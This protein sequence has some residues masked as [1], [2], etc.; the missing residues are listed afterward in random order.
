MP[1]VMTPNQASS[2]PVSTTQSPTTAM[3]NEYKSQSDNCDARFVCRD[4]EILC[5]KGFVA[6]KSR[7]MK[8]YLDNYHVV[9]MPR[10]YTDTIQICLDI[11]YFGYSNRTPAFEGQ[12]RAY[13]KAFCIQD[14][15]DLV[16]IAL[17]NGHGD[18]HASVKTGP[19][20]NGNSVVEEPTLEEELNGQDARSDSGDELETFQDSDAEN[21]APSTETPNP[22]SAAQLSSGGKAN[23][24]LPPI[25]EEDVAAPV[26]EEPPP[27]ADDIQPEPGGSGMQAPLTQDEVEVV[28]VVPAKPKRVDIVDLASSEDEEL[29]LA[30][31]V[32]LQETLRSAAAVE[33][34]F[35]RK[36][37][38][39]PV[40]ST[41]I[42]I[43]VKREH[44][45]DVRCRYCKRPFSS[46]Q[47]P[48]HMKRA[49]RRHPQPLSSKFLNAMER[50]V[51]IVNFCKRKRGNAKNRTL[52]AKE[53]KS[54]S[55]TMELL[56][57]RSNSRHH[58][59]P[60]SGRTRLLLTS[61]F[62]KTL[63]RQPTARIKIEEED[64][65]WGDND[66]DWGDE[67]V[68]ASTITPSSSNSTTSTTVKAQPVPTTTTSSAPVQ[69]PTIRPLASIN[70]VQT[71]NTLNLISN[72]RPVQTIS[73]SM[74]L[75][76]VPTIRYV[77]PVQTFRQ[78]SHHSMPVINTINPR[79]GTSLLL[80]NQQQMPPMIPI[81]PAPQPIQ[82]IT[83]AQPQLRYQQFPNINQVQTSVPQLVRLTPAPVSVNPL[84]HLI[85]QRRPGQPLA[86]AP[87]PVVVSA[88]YQPAMSNAVHTFRQNVA[89]RQI[90]P[91]Q[92][93]F[94][95]GQQLALAPQMNINRSAP[96]ADH[97][98]GQPTASNV[99]LPIQEID[100]SVSIPL[101]PLVKINCQ[102]CL[103]PQV[104][105]RHKTHE[106]GCTKKTEPQHC[107]RCDAVFFSSQSLTRHYDEAHGLHIVL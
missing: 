65:V 6:S 5:H 7:E 18:D 64:L 104:P 100:L 12:T 93:T 26:A 67:T 52:K 32:S 70:P 74:P 28:P 1:G 11:L 81:V 77:N 75:Q 47:L 79:A 51:D 25:Q 44:I 16:G 101:P 45:T 43:E 61:I 53:A 89:P 34:I 29:E 37:P 57:R 62:R 14:V 99:S 82:I 13:A 33:E 97:S 49:H 20:T 86:A 9:H 27:L 4:G 15:D 72:V 73:Q 83:N 94:N 36:S 31:A 76:Q 30:K 66:M 95:T 35:K 54:L 10:A 107:R 24:A 85:Q 41:F 78:A 38:S 40:A 19:V 22:V 105:N 3:K 46:Y 60:S 17:T 21:D 98:Y 68:P 96:R 88:A 103:K 59:K 91:A 92:Q 106:K 84:G 23:E 42:P 56:S 50:P 69:P 71:S 80:I 58:T 2:R 102:Y 63:D 87:Q 55:K 8:M 90:A 39:P 48:D